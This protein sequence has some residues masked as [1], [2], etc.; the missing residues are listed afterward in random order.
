MDQIAESMFGGWKYIHN[1][2]N[3][4]NGRILV[5]WRPDYYKVCQI[6]TAAQEITFEVEYISQKLNFMVTF[7]YDFNT[8]EERNGQ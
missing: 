1:L 4:Y 7:V 2:E 6:K 5:S 3:H 8:R